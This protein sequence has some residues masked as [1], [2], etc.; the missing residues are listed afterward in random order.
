MI[1]T[2]EIYF[3]EFA[4][5]L[6]ALLPVASVRSCER[7]V[8]ILWCIMIEL[9]F[10]TLWLLLLPLGQTDTSA[11]SSK[12]IQLGDNQFPSRYQT[13]Q[14]IKTKSFDLF[15]HQCTCA[16]KPITTQQVDTQ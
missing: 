14:Q 15:Y 8:Q 5:K 4:G 13:N 7:V 11:I 12:S 3:G 6:P 9:Q 1:Q 2:S 10:I 16:I